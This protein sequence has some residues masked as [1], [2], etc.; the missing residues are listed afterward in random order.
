MAARQGWR[1]SDFLGRKCRSTFVFPGWKEPVFLKDRRSN[2]R[3][4]IVGPESARRKGGEAVA[5]LFDVILFHFRR[6]K[7]CCFHSERAG[8]PFQ[9]VGCSDGSPLLTDTRLLNRDRRPPHFLPDGDLVFRAIEGGSNFLYRMKVDGTGR[10]KIVSERVLDAI[11]VSPDGRWIVA[12][13][14]FLNQKSSTATKAYPVDGS[15][16]VTLCLTYCRI[17]WDIVGKFLYIHFPYSPE[18]SG[19]GTYALPVPHDSGI[20]KLPPAG[21]ERIECLK[22]AKPA[23]VIPQ[24]VDSAVSPTIYAYSR[25]STSRNLYRI[26]LP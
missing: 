5:W 24:F 9:R 26:Q 13:A 3:F 1:P 10:R 22:N 25:E 21:I 23:A 4:R 6:W 18:L 7:E 20:P 2:P 17:N 12:S 8:R 19:G 14:P 16:P 11:A 15:E